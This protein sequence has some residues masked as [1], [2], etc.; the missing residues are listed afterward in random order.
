MARRTFRCYELRGTTA[1]EF[2]FLADRVAAVIPQDPTETIKVGE[3]P[4][5]YQ[6]YEVWFNEDKLP[7]SLLLDIEKLSR[8]APWL[9]RLEMASKASD[10]ESPLGLMLLSQDHRT[11]QK[12]ATKAGFSL[13][14]TSLPRKRQTIPVIGTV[15]EH[16][17][18][19]TAILHRARGARR[20]V[21]DAATAPH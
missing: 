20:P 9:L 15:A 12:D 19:D 14:R 2:V 7:V 13:V 18:Q 8:V 1:S 21:I 11:W 4:E 5:D 10:G 17:P 6:V 16:H 3:D